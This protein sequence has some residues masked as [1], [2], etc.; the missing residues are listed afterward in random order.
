MLPAI[1]EAVPKHA[2]NVADNDGRQNLLEHPDEVEDCQVLANLLLSRGVPVTNLRHLQEGGL[3]DE[4][5]E[6]QTGQAH[7]FDAQ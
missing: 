4:T 6:A 1:T 7:Q 2:E 3:W 5:A